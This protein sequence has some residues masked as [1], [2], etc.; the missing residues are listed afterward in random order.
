[1]KRF[2]SLLVLFLTLVSVN[3]GFALTEYID[4]RE[5]ATNA[6]GVLQTN[7]TLY[8]VNIRILNG[9][10]TIYEEYFGYNT[11]TTDEFGIFRIQ[12]GSGNVVSGN[13]STITPHLTCGLIAGLKLIVAIHIELLA[14]SNY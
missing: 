12:V 6:S 7:T 2:F 3:V 13:Y 14:R 5:F 10:T 4:F 9:S 1:M 8:E 11:I